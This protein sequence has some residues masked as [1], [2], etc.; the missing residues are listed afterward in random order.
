MF[1]LLYSQKLQYT[2]HLF[3]KILADKDQHVELNVKKRRLG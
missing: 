1:L 3:L 2:E